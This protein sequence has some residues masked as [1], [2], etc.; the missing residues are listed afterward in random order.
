MEYKLDLPIF[1]VFVCTKL[2]TSWLVFLSGPEPA[3]LGFYRE[4]K[5]RYVSLLG[6]FL[7]SARNRFSIDKPQIE[8]DF[9]IR[10]V[11]RFFTGR[12]FLTDTEKSTR[13]QGDF[14]C[15]Y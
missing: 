11:S 10:F 4:K 6:R 12:P 8:R 2:L 3:W 5:E 9:N 14:G 1:S 13:S 7:W 15:R